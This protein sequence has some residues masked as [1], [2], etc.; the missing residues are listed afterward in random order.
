MSF[1]IQCSVMPGSKRISWRN[2]VKK[3]L[4]KA[5]LEERERQGEK[6][7][8]RKSISCKLRIVVLQDPF[9]I[10]EGNLYKENNIFQCNIIHSIK[11]ETRISLFYISTFLV[12]FFVNV[13]ERGWQ[14]L[15]VFE[16]AKD[17]MLDFEIEN[18][19]Y[20]WKCLIT[21]IQ[22]ISTLIELKYIIYSL[23]YVRKTK[24]KILVYHF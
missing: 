14:V 7:F 15:K 8:L 23:L 3:M 20:G 24:K 17:E 13:Q 18:L 11:N 4:N 2:L 9:N 1:S 22:I 10:H 6:R 16:Y 12:N 19:K 5:E 21:N